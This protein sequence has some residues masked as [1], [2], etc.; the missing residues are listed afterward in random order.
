MTAG[1]LKHRI[2]LQALTETSDGHDGYTQT[3]ANIAPARRAAMV[4]PLR[5]RD[6]ERAQQIDPRA[7]HDVILRFWR[8]YSTDLDGGRARLVFHDGDV[9]DRT[10]EIVGPPVETKSRSALTLIAKEAA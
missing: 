6:L 8:T 7:T 5:G 2:T 9:G 3:W 10:F 4:R 1:D